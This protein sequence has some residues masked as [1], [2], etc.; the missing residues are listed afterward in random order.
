MT[1]ITGISQAFAAEF[2]LTAQLWG[3]VIGGI[4]LIAVLIAVRWAVGPDSFILGVSAFAVIGLSAAV[5]WFDMWLIVFIALAI[6]LILV[7]GTGSVSLPFGRGGG[8]A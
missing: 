2:G 5:G 7:F 1:D 3:Y 8:G 6:V 4:V